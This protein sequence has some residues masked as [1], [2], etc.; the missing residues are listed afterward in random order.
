MKFKK[1][2]SLFIVIAIIF[3]A[4]FG[5]GFYAKRIA[6]RHK[7]ALSVRPLVYQRDA[8]LLK[9]AFTDKMVENNRQIYP[10]VENIAQLKER[11]NEYELDA[12][13]FTSAFADLHIVNTKLAFDLLRVDYSLADRKYSA[14]AYFIQHADRA[15]DEKSSCLIIPGSGKNQSTLIFE[16]KS[17]VHNYG[18]L[19]AFLKQRSD[20]FILIKP[21]EDI[22]AIHNGKNKLSRDFFIAHLK[23]RSE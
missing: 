13:S 8:E 7:R 3:S 10:P 19:V 11:I 23:L 21:N 18:E 2:F 12:S 5:L 17:D 14:Y 9:D 22:L 16:Q 1:I 6:A 4:G 20:I 15:V